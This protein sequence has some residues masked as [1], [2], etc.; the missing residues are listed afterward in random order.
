MRIATLVIVS[1][2]LLLVDMTIIPFF[3][4][5]GTYGSMLFA[6]SGLFVILGD[7]DDA[8]LMAMLTGILQ[9]I[10]FPYA[11]GLNALVNLFV[12][13]G[14]TRLGSSLKAGTKAMPVIIVSAGAAVKNLVIYGVML[15]FGYRGNVLS[16]PV[17]AAYVLLFGLLIYNLVKKFKRI[18]FIKKEW[19]FQ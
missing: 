3:S 15:I 12:F 19:K 14:I 10:F 2:L 9:D 7:Y 5:F 1:I 13:L 6:F 17:G 16:I 11:F 4:F 8:V 18:P